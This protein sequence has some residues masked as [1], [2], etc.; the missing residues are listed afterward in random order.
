MSEKGR[1]FWT[2]TLYTDKESAILG[3][4]KTI[5]KRKK[6]QQDEI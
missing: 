2:K 4:D 6:G 1:F 3:M 5:E